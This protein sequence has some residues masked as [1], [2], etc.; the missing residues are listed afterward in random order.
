VTLNISSI[1]IFRQ[2]KILSKDSS[3]SPSDS[4]VSLSWRHWSPGLQAEVADDQFEDFIRAGKS[5]T[6]RI[7]ELNDSLLESISKL[8][9]LLKSGCTIQKGNLNDSD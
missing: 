6:I 5:T 4:V 8:L 7:R 1:D 2:Q 3:C 9:L